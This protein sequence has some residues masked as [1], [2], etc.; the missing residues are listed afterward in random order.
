MPITYLDFLG[1]VKYPRYSIFQDI[2]TM[3]GLQNQ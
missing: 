1:V 2:L 3:S